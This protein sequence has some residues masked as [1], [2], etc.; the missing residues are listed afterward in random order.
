[1]KNKASDKVSKGKGRKKAAGGSEV[2]CYGNEPF[3]VKKANDS[4]KA[5]EKSG[6]P[7][8]LQKGST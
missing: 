5:L 2:R 4:K 7:K 3:F 1:M 6:M 8:G